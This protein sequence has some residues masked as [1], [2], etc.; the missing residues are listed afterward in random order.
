MVGVSCWEN[1]QSTPDILLLPQ[2]ASFFGVTVD[3][4]MGY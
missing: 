2:L 3:E 4:L 1:K